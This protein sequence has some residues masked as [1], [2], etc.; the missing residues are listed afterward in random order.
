MP[1]YRNKRFPMINIKN[2]NLTLSKVCDTFQILFQYSLYCK[3]VPLQSNI[4]NHNNSN[5]R[6][7]SVSARIPSS[8]SR[9][10][11]TS[12]ASAATTTSTNI[13]TNLKI[14]PDL[15]HS[16][17]SSLIKSPTDEMRNKSMVPESDSNQPPFSDHHMDLM[18]HHWHHLY[19]YL[20]CFPDKKSVKVQSKEPQPHKCLLGQPL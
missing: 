16:T 8:I 18:V 7:T 2:S 17:K 11:A 10:T 14:E 1:T 15:S 12:K 19:K 4:N 9:S 5:V 13:S 20:T 6:S 3:Y